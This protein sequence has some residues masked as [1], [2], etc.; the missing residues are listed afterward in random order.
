M[1]AVGMRPPVEVGG[2]RLGTGPRLGRGPAVGMRRDCVWVGKARRF[3][4]LSE[5]GG[6][7]EEDAGFAGGAMR[8]GF[9]GGAMD[10][11]GEGAEAL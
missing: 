4:A 9:G 1:G 6:M 2:P 7:S 11:V 3:E 5:G 10:M 8:V